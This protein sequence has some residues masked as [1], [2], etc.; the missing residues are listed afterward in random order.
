MAEAVVGL[1]RDADAREKM[2]RAGREFVE[3]HW[4]WEAHFERLEEWL[5]EAAQS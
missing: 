5:L 3:S 4:S 1:L 2:G